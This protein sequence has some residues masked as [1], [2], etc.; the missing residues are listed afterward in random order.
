MISHILAKLYGII[1]NKKISF[2]L[3]RHGEIS[4]EKSRF[5]RHY[6]TINHVVTLRIIAKECCNNNI[7]LLCYC[8]DFRKYFDIVPRDKL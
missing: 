4:K 7:D 6:S 1:L 5:R 3:E 2:W 8:V